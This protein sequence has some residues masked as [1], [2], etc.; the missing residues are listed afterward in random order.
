MKIK[1]ERHTGGRSTKEV[2]RKMWLIKDEPNKEKWTHWDTVT[3]M[4]EQEQ[5]GEG[6]GR[7]E[8]DSKE[9]EERGKNGE[10]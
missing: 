7:L 6:R 3:G 2:Q 1:M 8:E 10:G 4:T 9:E 5:G